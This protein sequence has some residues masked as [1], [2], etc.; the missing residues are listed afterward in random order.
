MKVTRR[1]QVTIPKILPERT[2]IDEGTEVDF[3][4]EKGRVHTSSYNFPLS[5]LGN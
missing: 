5:I 1:G 3:M 2:G 4:E